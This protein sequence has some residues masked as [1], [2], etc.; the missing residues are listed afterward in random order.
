MDK[1]DEENAEGTGQSQ[2][3]QSGEQVTEDTES[4]GEDQTHQ[5][6]VLC[7]NLMHADAKSVSIYCNKCGVCNC[8]FF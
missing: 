5:S 4:K 6:H 8:L 7:M 2:I 3:T 1:K